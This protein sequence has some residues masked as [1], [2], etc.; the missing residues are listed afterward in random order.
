MRY[1]TLFAKKLYKRLGVIIVV[2]VL[3]VVNDT[4]KTDNLGFSKIMF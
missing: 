2:N 4:G 1:Y 3:I